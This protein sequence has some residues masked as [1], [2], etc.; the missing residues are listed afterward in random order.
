MNRHTNCSN[1]KCFIFK[2]IIELHTFMSVKLWTIDIDGTGLR[3]PVAKNIV[4]YVQ[5]INSPYNFDL[6]IILC[7]SL[8]IF[9]TIMVN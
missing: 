1:K 8:N 2:K 4:R 6:L 9:S 3:P 5:L 7:I